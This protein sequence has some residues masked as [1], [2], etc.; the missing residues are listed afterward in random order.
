MFINM[1]IGEV[2]FG[3]LTWEK[4]SQNVLLND[5]EQVVEFILVSKVA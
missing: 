5:K 4:N 3:A 1:I 2:N